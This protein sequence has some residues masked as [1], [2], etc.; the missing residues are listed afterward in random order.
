M[1]AD[2]HDMDITSSVNMN[3]SNYWIYTG[4][5]EDFSEEYMI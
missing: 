1:W 2:K 4:K 5:E 3:S